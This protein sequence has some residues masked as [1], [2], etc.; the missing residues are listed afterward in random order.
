MRRLLATGALLAALLPAPTVQATT[1]AGLVVTYTQ[2]TTPVNRGATAKVAVHTGPHLK[3]SIKVVYQSGRVS[4]PG[5]GTK[6]S[7]AAG[8]VS[9]SW[10]VPSSTAKGAYPV[11]VTCQSGG[12]AGKAKRSMTIA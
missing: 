10:T 12:S 2:F 1:P 8:K 4:L 9:W 3:C 5:L 6:T 11:T 7:S